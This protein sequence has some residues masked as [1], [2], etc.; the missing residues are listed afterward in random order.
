MELSLIKSIEQNYPKNVTTCFQETLDRWL[1]LVPGATWKMLE[2]AITNVNRQ[3]L[4]LN[5]VKNVYGEDMCI[6]MQ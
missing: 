5:P 1:K 3:N 6:C 2:I 4:H